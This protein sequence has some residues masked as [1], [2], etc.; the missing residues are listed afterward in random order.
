MNLPMR[1]LAYGERD[2]EKKRKPK[3]SLIEGICLAISSSNQ[4]NGQETRPSYSY[5]MRLLNIPHEREVLR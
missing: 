4:R 1:K 5:I 2:F 3:G